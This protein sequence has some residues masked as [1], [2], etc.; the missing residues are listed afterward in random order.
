M[1][2]HKGPTLKGIRY[3]N[4]QIQKFVFPAQGQILLDRVVHQSS[5]N[6]AGFHTIYIRG[7]LTIIFRSTV[8]FHVH[9]QV[10]PSGLGICNKEICTGAWQSM[11]EGISTNY[12]LFSQT[13]SA[14][15]TLYYHKNNDTQNNKDNT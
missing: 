13:I 9:L 4:T 6:I 5:E 11:N 3:F 2:R 10:S 14:K 15:S 12:M 7:H 8:G 1:W